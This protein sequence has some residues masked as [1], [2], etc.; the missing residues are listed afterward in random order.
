MWGLP[1]V[2]TQERWHPK[3][4]TRNG[5][6]ANCKRTFIQER[7]WAHS[8]TPRRGR[9]PCCLS[10]WVRWY[11]KEENTSQGGGEGVCWKIPK[12]PVK[13]HEEVKSQGNIPDNCE[14]ISQDSLY[15]PLTIAH[16]HSGFPEWSGWSFLNKYSVNPGSWWVEE[17]SYLFCD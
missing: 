13:S 1:H 16:L 10:S 4:L 14:V 2:L 17:C 3:S 7:S 12:I 11:L 6:A 5:L 15:E 9:G 8:H